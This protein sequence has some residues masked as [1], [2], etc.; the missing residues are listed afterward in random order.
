MAEPPDKMTTEKEQHSN[1]SNNTNNGNN[2]NN[3]N[4]LDGTFYRLEI[5]NYKSY[6]LFHVCVILCY[7]VLLL[8]LLFNA[9]AAKSNKGN[10]NLFSIEK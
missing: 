7:C 10:S 4:D 3:D 6:I 8:L 2:D 5:N 9:E 1:N